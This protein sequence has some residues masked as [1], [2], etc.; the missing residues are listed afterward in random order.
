MSVT[1]GGTHLPLPPTTSKPQPPNP[2][3]MSTTNITNVI[4]DV[5]TT[6]L[7]GSNNWQMWKYLIQCW[8]GS[9]PGFECCLHYT[10]ATGCRP[11]IPSA[12]STATYSNV[13]TVPFTVTEDDIDKFE[14]NEGKVRYSLVKNLT[15]EVLGKVISCP[16]AKDVWLQ[17]EGLYKKSDYFNI[18]TLKRP[19][20]GHH[21]VDGTPIDQHVSQMQM[22]YAEM[23]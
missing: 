17:L 11:Q 9:N 12:A 14:A 21:M 1:P 15:Q 16:S 18:I 8:L 4:K 19:L 3:T 23:R 22:W 6:K 20:C 5:D 13:A 10:P 7:K 2:P